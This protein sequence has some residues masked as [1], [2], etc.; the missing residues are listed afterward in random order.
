LAGALEPIGR[1]G[2]LPVPPLN[3]LGD[4]G[5]GGMLLAFGV[6]CAVLEARS[7]GCGQVVDAAIVDG[8][9]A[10][11]TMIHG[12]RAMGR[13]RD[14]RGSN[15]LDTGAPFY[16]V[17]ETADGEFV[18]IGSIEPQFY[19][20]LLDKLGLAQDADFADQ[21]DVARWPDRKVQL[22]DLFRR[23]TRDDWNA[24]LEGS[25]V[26]Y[27]PVLTMAEVADHPHNST[28]ETFVTAHGVIQPA[29][30]PRFSRTPGRIQGPPPT[31]GEH[32]DQVLKDWGLD[33]Q[34]IAELR[35]AEVIR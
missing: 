3:L 31:P 16:D 9:A 13:W 24:L 28:R 11:T 25:D 35:D 8:T 15:M 7:S 17:Y 26:C 33:S 22:T 30:A 29:P 32:T 5:G 10:L 2:A 21:H 1:A 19:R 18:S 14:K 23:R 12:L 34:A 4:F 27:A 6:V 20:L